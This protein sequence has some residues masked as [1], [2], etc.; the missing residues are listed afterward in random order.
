MIPVM[1]E[2]EFEYH[3]EFISFPLLCGIQYGDQTYGFVQLGLAP[4]L[5]MQAKMSVSSETIGV[6]EFNAKELATSYDITGLL[7]AGIGK[8]WSEWGIYAVVH[9]YRSMVSISNDE[10][11][12][13][14]H[15]R[16]WRRGVFL[17]V[18]YQLR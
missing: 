9:F 6:R 14:T 17:G 11:Y 1:G 13:D 18:R 8:Q 16:L 7:K 4:S 15:M 3:Y 5:L 12:M 2:G 10:Y